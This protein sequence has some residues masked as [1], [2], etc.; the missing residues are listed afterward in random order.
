MSDGETRRDDLDDEQPSTEGRPSAGE[1]SEL[2]E[3]VEATEA[4]AAD[5]T[6]ADAAEGSAAASADE[7]DE[8]E[9]AAAAKDEDED[10]PTAAAKDEPSERPARREERSR[11]DPAPGA[12]AAKPAGGGGS[13][14]ALLVAIGLVIGATG[15]WAARE[16]RAHTLLRGNTP[17]AGGSCAAWES[18][19]CESLGADAFSCLEAKAA[20]GLLPAAACD[21]ALDAVPDTLE[22]V[23][24]ARKS[25]DDLVNKLCTDLGSETQTCEM[26]RTKSD[27]FPPDR[28][29]AMLDNY[30]QV[31][32][33]LRMMEQGPRMPGMAHGASPHGAAPHRAAPQ[34]AA[35]QNAAPQGAAPQGAAPQG[36]PAPAPAPGTSSPAP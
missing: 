29:Q 18:R 4:G 5:A 11:R 15:G 26:V 27:S 16:A 31:V 24:A 36:S 23:K 3:P 25:C 9:D 28:C 30:D 33:Q 34:G 2:K 32:G 1:G 35:P 13:R 19:I 10:E 17:D 21:E 20:A 7:S 22:K 6:A 14:A 8:S 12:G